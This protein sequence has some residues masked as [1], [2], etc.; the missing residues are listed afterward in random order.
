MY[1][2]LCNNSILKE[3]TFRLKNRSK[4]GEQIWADQSPY[5]ICS[6]CNFFMW[7]VHIRKMQNLQITFAYI[8]NGGQKI[9]SLF[10]RAFGWP[11]FAHGA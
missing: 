10:F 7:H 4:R 11:N 6:F 3:K 5:Q 9:L 8:K 1:K 2:R